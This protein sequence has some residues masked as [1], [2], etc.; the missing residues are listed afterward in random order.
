M[1]QFVHGSNFPLLSK[2]KI[3][4][5]LEGQESCGLSNELY[6]EARRMRDLFLPYVLAFSYSS[7]KNFYQSSCIP[8]RKPFRIVVRF[9]N[10]YQLRQLRNDFS[11]SRIYADG[12]SCGILLML[13]LFFPLLRVNH[14]KLWHLIACSL[15]NYIL[16]LQKQLV[17]DHHSQGAEFL[18]LWILCYVADRNKSSEFYCSLKKQR[19]RN[20]E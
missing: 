4:F 17:L 15:W 5:L 13:H 14:I 3:V 7:W 8:W 11:T 19:N 12:F 9:P 1:Y 20:F 16:I 6:S 2:F 18:R 10:M